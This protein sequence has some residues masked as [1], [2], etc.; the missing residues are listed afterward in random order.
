MATNQLTITP[1]SN[2]E[3][4]QIGD[5]SF[6]FGIYKNGAT[7]LRLPVGTILARNTTTDQLVPLDLS[8]TTT[9]ANS[10][11]GFVT[12]SRD[13]DVNEAK[14]ITYVTGGKINED[15]IKLP[16]GVTMASIIGVSGTAGAKNL[17]DYLT[18]M[19]FDLCK[20]Q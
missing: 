2:K 13:F 19:G 20:P 10:P 3:T 6:E 4:I 1:L 7:A 16:S 14:K 8:A 9:N 15:V 12:D 5:N 11:V 17:R 18:G